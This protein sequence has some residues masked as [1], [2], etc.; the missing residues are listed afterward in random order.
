[1]LWHPHCEGFGAFAISHED[2]YPPFSELTSVVTQD[3]P[4]VSDDE[5]LERG[6]MER[7]P[8]GIEPD[9]GP[10]RTPDPGL[11]RVVLPLTH[12]HKHTISDYG[13]AGPLGIASVEAPR[14]A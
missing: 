4:V 5:A 12:T 1:M 10:A 6:L 9:P 2:L 14:L 13:A 3:A 7:H 8:I 11:P